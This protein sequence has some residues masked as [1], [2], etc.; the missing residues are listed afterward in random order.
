MTVALSHPYL[1]LLCS[2]HHVQQWLSTYGS[3]TSS[4]SISWELVRNAD[5]PASS[6]ISWTRTFPGGAQQF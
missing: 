1:T 4:I 6:Q 5:S 2:I 3:W